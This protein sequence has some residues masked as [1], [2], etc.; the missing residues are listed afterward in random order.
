MKQAEDFWWTAGNVEVRDFNIMKDLIGAK[1]LTRSRDPLELYPYWMVTLPLDGL[2]P[3]MVTTILVKIWAD[4][5]EVIDILALGYG[6]EPAT[7]STTTNPLHEENVIT[8]P[9]E[10][11]ADE[12]PTTQSTEL[13]PAQ[14]P[15]PILS[16][17]K[18]DTPALSTDT[19]IA[20]GVATVIAI[21]VVTVIIKKKCK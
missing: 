7:E 1:L 16:A 2:Y 21:V 19:L 12:P 13:S 3:G 14:K 10:S 4:T 20:V 15:S 8:P 5:A 9:T 17:Q 18:I 6:G 11:Q